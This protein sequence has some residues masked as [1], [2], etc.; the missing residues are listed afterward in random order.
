VRKLTT[1]LEVP[2]LDQAVTLTIKT[3]CPAKWVL[4]DMETGETYSPYDTPGPLQWKK[5]GRDQL[6]GLNL[7]RAYP[8]EKI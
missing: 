3:K 5:V 2:E 7:T 4:F 8:N 6:P 1:G